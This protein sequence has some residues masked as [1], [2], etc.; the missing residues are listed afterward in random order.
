MQSE[1]KHI[2]KQTATRTGEDEQVYK[3]IGTAV[4]ASLN[5]TLRRP[6]TLITK[7]KGVGSWYLRKKRMEIIVEIFPPNFEKDDFQSDYGI[8]KHENKLDL[9]NLF[10]ARL[11][12]YDKYLEIRNEIRKI[13]RETQTLLQPTDREDKST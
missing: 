6:S 8:L 1:V 4:F 9:Y 2:Y 3:D 13:R 10:K 12:D 11:A 5:R 7:L